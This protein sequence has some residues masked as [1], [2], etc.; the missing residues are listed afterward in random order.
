MKIET[1]NVMRTQ[2]FGENACRIGH[3]KRREGEREL[4]FDHGSLIPARL[5]ATP[6]NHARLRVDSYGVRVAD[7]IA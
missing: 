2:V 5:W 7:E 1:D 3:R 6:S 4:L